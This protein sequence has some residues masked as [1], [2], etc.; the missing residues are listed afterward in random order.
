MPGLQSVSKKRPAV[1]QGG[2][3]S[4]KHQSENPS[5]TKLEERKVQKR[6]RPVTQPII[7]ASGLSD[8][9]EDDDEDNF[10]EEEP[11]DQEIVPD[12]MIVDG[13]SIRDPNGMSM[14]TG[15]EL[16]TIHNVLNSC[17]RIT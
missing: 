17:K 12:E 11:E 3:K 6:S 10:E 15:T 13:A 16:Q 14:V 8:D 5:L 7:P 9:D 4:K 1:S 2:P